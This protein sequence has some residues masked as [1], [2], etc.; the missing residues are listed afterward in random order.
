MVNSEE[1]MDSLHQDNAI[2][3]RKDQ[4]ILYFKDKD[5]WK[6]IQVMA[7]KSLVWV[8]AHNCLVHFV[9]PHHLSLAEKSY[10]LQTAT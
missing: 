1:E 7:F 9:K 6:P 4:R 2:A 5:G 10:F 8:T 3:F